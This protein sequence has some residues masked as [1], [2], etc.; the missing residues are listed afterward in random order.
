MASDA[1][2]IGYRQGL[3][4][5]Y[6]KINTKNNKSARLQWKGGKSADSY[7]I[8]RSRKKNGTY[9]AVKTVA[10]NRNY[11]V[12]KKIKPT[13]K[14]YYKIKA[15]GHLGGKEIEGKESPIRSICVSGIRNPKISVKKGRLKQICFVSM[16]LRK[17]QGDYADIHISINRKKFKKLKLVSNRISKYKGKF[18]IQYVIRNKEIRFKVRTYRKKGKK[19]IYSHFSN[20]VGVKV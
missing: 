1:N 16:R 13:V 10:K 2:R 3:V 7:R 17:Y 6:F 11:F 20:V 5:T 8:Y 15:L 4:V 18:E 12:D 19:K 9:Q 14:Y